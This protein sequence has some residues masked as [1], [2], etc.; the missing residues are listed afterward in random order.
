M[1]ENFK[2]IISSDKPVADMYIVSTISITDRKSAQCKGEDVSSWWGF[3]I[4]RFPCW[5]VTWAQ[6]KKFLFGISSRRQKVP[7]P[8]DEIISG[9]AIPLDA[10]IHFQVPEIGSPWLSLVCT[11][12]RNINYNSYYITSL[13]GRQNNSQEMDCTS[14]LSVK[15]WF[16]FHG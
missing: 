14:L 11:K 1:T 6:I 8:K 16:K 13:E 3:P 7:G 10:P 2:Q 9:S 15:S 4:L 5:Y 12:E